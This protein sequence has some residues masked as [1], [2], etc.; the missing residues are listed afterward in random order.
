MFV[1]LACVIGVSAAA[2]Q[3]IV[4]WRGDGS[5]SFP[6]AS[7]PTEWSKENNIVWAAEMPSWSNSTPIIVGDKVF[8]GSDKTDLLCV[9]RSDGKVLWKAS[10]TYFDPMSPEELKVAKAIQKQA[11]TVKA[12]IK[13]VDQVRRQPDRQLK[14]IRN[15]RKKIDDLQKQLAELQDKD[16]LAKKI[17]GLKKESEGLLKKLKDAP[18]NAKLKK[19]SDGIANRLKELQTA[20]LLKQ[21]I[22]DL[23]KQLGESKAELDAAPDE[24]G[25]KA[26]VDE[27][28]RIRNHLKKT[29]LSHLTKYDLPSIHP[30]TGYSTCTPVSDGEKVWAVLSN[31]MA[32]CYDLDGNR[33]WLRFVEKPPNG[34]GYSASPLLVG[35]NLI[36]QFKGFIALDK[37]TGEEVWR[38][39]EASARFGTPVL[40]KIGDVDVIVTPNGDIV[41]ADDGKMLAKK[42]SQLDYCAPVVHD[43]VAYFIQ[44]GGKAIKLP[45]EITD[46]AKFETLWTASGIQG[47]RYYASPVY[48][49]GL[50]YGLNKRSHLTVIDAKTGE[51]VYDK[52][53]ELGGTAY[54]SVACAGKYVFISSDN[55]VTL[56]IE[57]GRE[58][59]EVAKNKL[60]N[61]RSSPVFAGD[62]MYVRGLKKL[63]CIGK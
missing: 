22:E 2:A 3:D 1:C 29:E 28:K 60:E 15:L 12:A 9:R 41:R 19:K 56:V 58:Y 49:D 47:D 43:G 40:T 45:E 63:Y 62:R 17:G 26:R 39:S 51:T 53:L 34:R 4:G 6:K 14:G 5:G 33:K 30:V 18:E 61:F 32:G 31:G 54:P 20:E 57:A 37:E 35:G 38:T 36:V 11:D 24:E 59:K 13:A 7:P 27:L 48:H 50:I 52:K 21:K 25:L 55:S 46:D 42:L 10:N 16:A 23:G 44:K 8:V